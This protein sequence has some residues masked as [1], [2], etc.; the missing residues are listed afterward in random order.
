M[1]NLDLLYPFNFISF[2]LYVVSNLVLRYLIENDMKLKSSIRNMYA[3]INWL[4]IINAVGQN[5]D[6]K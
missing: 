2:D 3:Y 6:L 4:P 5:H 1:N